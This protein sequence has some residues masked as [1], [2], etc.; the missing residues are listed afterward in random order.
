MSENTGNR[1]YGGTHVITAP[2]NQPVLFD[3][4]LRDAGV[5][6]GGGGEAGPQGPPG[7]PGPAGPEGPPG[8][9][10]QAAFDA[11]IADLQAQIDEL[12]AAAP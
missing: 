9:V 10:T 8:E 3:D 7:E 1:A 5:E 11:A 12:K 6:P 4:L 2:T